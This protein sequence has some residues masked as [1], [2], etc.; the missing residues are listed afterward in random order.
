MTQAIR[1]QKQTILENM[2]FSFFFVVLSAQQKGCKVKKK[3]GKKRRNNSVILST[4]GFIYA[5]KAHS[6]CVYFM[7]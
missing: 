3:R 4:V 7:E 1:A 6:V 5:L 2:I